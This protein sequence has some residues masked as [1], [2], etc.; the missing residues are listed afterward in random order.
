M[1][2]PTNCASGRRRKTQQ[3]AQFRSSTS[4]HMRYLFLLVSVFYAVANAESHETFQAR[5]GVANFRVIAINNGHP[6][7]NTYVLSAVTTSGSQVLFKGEDGGW[8]HA[9]CL[10]TKGGKQLL[11]FQSYCGGSACLEGKYGVV[12]PT[13]LSLLLKPSA[14]NV[15]NHKELSALLGSPALHLGQYKEAFCCGK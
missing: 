7:D 11:V 9:A 14:K 2:S 13:S 5:C 3:P 15:E 1:H 8:F 12:D 4:M 6:L 10:T